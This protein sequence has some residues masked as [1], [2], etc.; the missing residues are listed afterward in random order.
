MLNSEGG[1]ARS[2]FRS[3]NL[4]EG[5]EERR[6]D[7]ENKEEVGDAVTPP[8]QT[9]DSLSRGTQVEQQGLRGSGGGAAP[10]DGSRLQQLMDYETGPRLGTY[11][12]SSR[13]R[14]PLR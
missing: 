2:R 8:W 6:E 1:R 11:G 3:E 10:L 12:P 4:P 5:T 9:A 7:K 14:P 13:A